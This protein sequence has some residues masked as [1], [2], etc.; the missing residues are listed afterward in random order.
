MDENLSENTL[1]PAS[2][3]ILLS[4][5][6]ATIHRVSLSSSHWR[7]EN[8]M[9][10]PHNHPTLLSPHPCTQSVLLDEIQATHF[11]RITK[12][13]PGN[14]PSTSNTTPCYLNIACMATSFAAHFKPLNIDTAIANAAYPVIQNSTYQKKREKK[15]RKTPYKPPTS[16]KTFHLTHPIMP[17]YIKPLNSSLPSQHLNPKKRRRKKRN[18]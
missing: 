9:T 11:S 3:S 14:F 13:G 17:L 8:Y 7:N 1:T 2:I 10:T 4:P 12:G 15:K 6:Y 18:P 5:P 16:T